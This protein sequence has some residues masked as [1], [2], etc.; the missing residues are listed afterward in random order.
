MIPANKD[1]SSE[2][3]PAASGLGGQYLSEG[4]LIGPFAQLLTMDKLPLRGAL[5]DDQLEIIEKAGIV[6]FD[7]IISEIGNYNVL[8]K[9]YPYEIA[10]ELN[11]DYVCLPGMIDAHTHIC[12]AGSRAK[13]YAP[14]L[15]DSS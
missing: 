2:N 7:G 11:D 15:S 12:W 9:K 3:S 10:A 14:K 8:K 5:K 4:I 13:D 6:Y 1:F